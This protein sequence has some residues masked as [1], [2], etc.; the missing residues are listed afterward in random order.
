MPTDT[1]Y[2][3]TGLAS[4]RKAIDRIFR[5]K[6]RRKKLPLPIFCS[7]FSQV[8]RVADK[9]NPVAKKLI[10]AFWPGA[11]TLVFPCKSAKF[12]HLAYQDKIGIRISKSPVVQKILRELRQPIIGTSANRSGDKEIRLATQVVELFNSQ[13]DLILNGGNLSRSLPST[14]VDV[15]SDKP[16][17]LRKGEISPKMINSILGNEK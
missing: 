8:K 7:S 3:L 6:G 17:I 16:K 5:I 14:V 4:D 11:L 9:I 10:Q 2:G 12:S 13:V 1:V 15:S